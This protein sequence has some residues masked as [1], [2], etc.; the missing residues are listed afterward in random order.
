MKEKK[1]KIIYDE[2]DDNIDSGPEET[3]L[4]INSRLS[5]SRS[6]STSKLSRLRDNILRVCSVFNY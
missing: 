6:Q 1:K 2:E 5:H 4:L 3:S